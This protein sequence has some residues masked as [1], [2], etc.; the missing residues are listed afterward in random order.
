LHSNGAPKETAEKKK[1][2][3]SE[4]VTWDLLARGTKLPA[5]E[6]TASASEKGPRYRFAGAGSKGPDIPGGNFRR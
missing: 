3:F 1:E 5:S 4:S 2:V 6:G